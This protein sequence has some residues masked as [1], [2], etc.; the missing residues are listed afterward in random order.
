MI[1]IRS[2][3]ASNF[4]EFVYEPAKTVAGIFVSGLCN[5]GIHDSIRLR[6]RDVLM[7]S[8][9]GKDWVKLCKC[10]GVGG[11][12]DCTNNPKLVTVPDLGARL[13]KI[14]WSIAIVSE[15]LFISN[16]QS[17]HEVRGKP[18]SNSIFRKNR[19]PKRWKYNFHYAAKL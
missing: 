12:V 14:I 15:I 4:L 10:G 5:D 7:Q 1:S 2:A 18:L 8:E 16:I 3:S 9:M 11:G 13:I 19:E 6:S 17:R